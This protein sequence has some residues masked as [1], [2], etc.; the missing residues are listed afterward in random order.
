MC[1][2]P[3]LYI[4]NMTPSPS[5]GSLLAFRRMDHF[6]VSPPSLGPLWASG[7]RSE[8]GGTSSSTGGSGS[9]QTPVCPMWG[10]QTP[11]PFVF[12]FGLLFMC[13][14]NIKS[15]QLHL[16]FM[17]VLSHV[18]L[19]K[20][21]MSRAPGVVWVSVKKKWFIRY[22]YLQHVK[23]E[24]GAVIQTTR[25]VWTR[26]LE[27]KKWGLVLT[28]LISSRHVKETWVDWRTPSITIKWCI[29]T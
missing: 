14:S 23:Q 8:A 24:V 17:K 20:V 22:F 9:L 25:C 13:F 11:P 21:F 2:W 27:G 1:W 3:V 12:F 18:F 4:S 6:C 10:R 19:L 26:S 28:L 29:N 15:R 7:S 16:I 5:P